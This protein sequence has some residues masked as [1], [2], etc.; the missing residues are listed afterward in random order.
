MKGKRKYFFAVTAIILFALILWNSLTQ[1]GIRDLKGNFKE[2]VF[3][4]N[5]QN[6][7]PIIRVYV[8]TVSDTLWS[9]MKQ[10]GNYMPH[11]KYGN[12]KVYFFLD[13]Q[14]WPKRIDENT[15][16]FDER[17][18]PYCIAVYEKDAMG[19]VSFKR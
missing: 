3:Y 9:E 15:A 17:F 18:K 14:P 1:P 5:E 11:T 4:R 12:T 7:G 10:Y 19:Q 8:V 16:V 2:R 13:N 6:T